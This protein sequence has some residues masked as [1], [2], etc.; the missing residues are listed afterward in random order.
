M[1]NCVDHL[2]CCH[3]FSKLLRTSAQFRENQG[4]EKMLQTRL[5]PSGSAAAT[6]TPANADRRESV[7]RI[8]QKQ[9]SERPHGL[10]VT[11]TSSRSLKDSQEKSTF[12]HFGNFLCHFKDTKESKTCSGDD[13]I[14][15]TRTVESSQPSLTRTELGETG[16]GVSRGLRFQRPVPELAAFLSGLTRVPLSTG[17]QTKAA[18]AAGCSNSSL[19]RTSLSGCSGPVQTENNLHRQKDEGGACLTPA[20]SSFSLFIMCL[21]WFSFGCFVLKFQAKRVFSKKM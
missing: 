15:V 20:V 7:E 12:P 6:K 1:I 18:P 5:S 11:H 14:S 16:E 10:G 13:K 21:V 4:R 8:H 3:S 9:A 19:F 2:Q 17:F